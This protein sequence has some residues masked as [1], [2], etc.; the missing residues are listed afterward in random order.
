MLCELHSFMQ[1]L[2]SNY[3]V[4]GTVLGVGD[5]A[6]NKRDK[7]PSFGQADSQLAGLTLIVCNPLCLGQMGEH[8]IVQSTG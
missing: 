4:S 5:T 3:C 6:V 1:L 8:E 7:T 2:L